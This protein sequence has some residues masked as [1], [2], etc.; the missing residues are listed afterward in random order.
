MGAFLLLLGLAV[1]AAAFQGVIL[2]YLWRESQP[3][4][5]TPL[6]AADVLGPPQFFQV[7]IGRAAHGAPG[8]AQVPLLLQRLEQHIRLEQAAAESFHRYPTV[9]SLHKH[10]ASPLLH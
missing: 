7:S 3:P 9:A 5:P 4:A 1:V 10:T 2:T 6:D 8:G